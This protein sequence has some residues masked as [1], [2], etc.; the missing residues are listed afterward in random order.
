MELKGVPG[1]PCVERA[2]A[3]QGFFVGMAVCADPRLHWHTSVQGRSEAA[4]I[5]SAVDQP[6]AG[7]VMEAAALQDVQHVQAYWNC[8]LVL[9]AESA[10]WE[11]SVHVQPFWSCSLASAG[12]ADRTPK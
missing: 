12:V 11:E 7:V 1:R 3:L 8:V 10:K 9:A 2:H 4:S 5:L 6:C